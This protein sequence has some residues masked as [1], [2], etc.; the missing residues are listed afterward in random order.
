MIASSHFG[1]ARREEA[2]AGLPIEH[3]AAPEALREAEARACAGVAPVE[4]NAS[5][6]YHREDILRVEPWQR[7]R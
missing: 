3:R 7:G 2:A 5:P 1:A 6:F 4:R